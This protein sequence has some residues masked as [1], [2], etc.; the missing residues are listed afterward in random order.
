MFI[1]PGDTP[2][3]LPFPPPPAPP[4]TFAVLPELP[5]P[6]PPPAKYLPGA[7]PGVPKDV[8]TQVM[9]DPVPPTPGVVV[10]GAFPPVD[11]DPP[12]PPPATA[13]NPAVPVPLPPLF[14]CGGDTGGVFPEP[15]AVAP[16]PVPPPPEP[17]EEADKTG[18]GYPQQAPPPPPDEVMD[19]NIEELPLDPVVP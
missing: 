15:P 9:G 13:V 14:P 19:E 16:V 7:G 5:P 11:P 1:V 2:G 3:V 10:F 18:E 6:P 8:G 17:P 4:D 12:P